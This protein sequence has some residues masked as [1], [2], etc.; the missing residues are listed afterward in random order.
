[1]GDRPVTSLRSIAPPDIPPERMAIGLTG[2]PGAGKSTVARWMEAAGARIVD[3]DVI[4]HRL[5]EPDSPVFN[6]V[7]REFGPSI[8]QADGK[9]D[10]RALA[11]MVFQTPDRLRRLNELIHPVLVEEITNRIE[12][13]RRSNEMGP[14]VVDAAL[15]Y[16]WGLNGLLDA[17]IAVTAPPTE[18]QQRLQAERGI[19]SEDFL[20]MD[21]AQ[22]QESDKVR[23]ADAVFHNHG[24][25]DALRRQV[26]RF[27]NR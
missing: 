19:P 20:R 5:L 21:A 11:R 16:E 15:I 22:M 8:F 6:E 10:R 12:R 2:N 18:R 13:F 24:D 17:V 4:G 26:D 25:L 9:I 23:Q 27:M 1:M 14:L 3:A 7:A